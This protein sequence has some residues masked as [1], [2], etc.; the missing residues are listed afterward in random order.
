MTALA[1][2][3]G[4]RAHS[5]G[6]Q[7]GLRLRAHDL[8]EEPPVLPTKRHQLVGDGGDLSGDRIG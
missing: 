4:I 3:R 8:R 2:A 6:G 5:Q 7:H 1:G